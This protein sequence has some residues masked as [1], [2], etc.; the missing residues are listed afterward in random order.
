MSIREANLVDGEYYHIYNRGNS[1]QKIFHDN[2]DYSRFVSLLCACNS[3]N[4]FR[5]FTLAKNESPYD[6]E[7][8]K[9]IVS[10]GAY[11]LMPN[12]F[13]ILIT[14]TEE[15]GVSKFMQKLGTAYSMYYNK[16]YKRTGGLFEGK[17]KSQHLGNDRYLK[18]LF[19][20]IHLNP[21]KLIQKNWKE[22]GIKNKK[23]A[24]EYLQN[25]KYSSYLDYL[26]IK[27]IQNKI[28]NTENFPEY[29]P[30]NKSF[31]KEIFEW[32]SYKEN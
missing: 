11:C 23:E 6:F 8:G 19:S 3:T 14:P 1:K 25:Y 16:K 29:F 20:Y 13:H 5:I 28:L 21:I 22:I 32:L 30:N 17:F 9:K 26:D 24:L 2:E 31:Q 7:R 12:H 18:Y 15:K 4:S 27:R 10:I